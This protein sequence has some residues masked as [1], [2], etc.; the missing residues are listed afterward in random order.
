M[1]PSSLARM[2][3]RLSGL[4]FDRSLIACVCEQPMTSDCA[5]G[6]LSLLGIGFLSYLDGVTYYAISSSVSTFTGA[7]VALGMVVHEFAEGV[8]TYAL[9]LRGGF[10]ERRSFLLAFAA[11]DV[12]TPL[13]TLTSFAFVSHISEPVLGLLLSLSAGT[14]V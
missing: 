13:G 3:H 6:L 10:S 7:L 5:L 12:S 9:L 4:G 11:G 8:V 1:A 2:P 14:L